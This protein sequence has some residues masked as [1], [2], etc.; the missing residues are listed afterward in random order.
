LVAIV[1]IFKEGVY[2]VVA[3]V[4]S[5]VVA[6][7]LVVVAAGLMATGLE[8]RFIAAVEL[9]NDT[10]N[11]L[12]LLGAVPLSVVDVNFI[13]AVGGWLKFRW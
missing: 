11:S 2:I 8:L 12:L 13:L 5:V 3:V 9:V 6:V 4:V 7:A 10:A 1:G